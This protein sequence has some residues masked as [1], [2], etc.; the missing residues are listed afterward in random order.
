M[1]RQ[2]KNRSIGSQFIPRTKDF[3]E[4]P[5]WRT[6]TL[7]A[8]MVIERIELEFLRHAGHENGKLKV[9]YQD[10]MD[11]GIARNAV[12]PALRE[13]TEMGF[14]KCITHGCAGNANY[15]APN[16]Y[17]LTY[18]P[19]MGERDYGKGPWR[20][21]TTMEAARDIARQARNDRSQRRWRPGN[22]RP[23]N[24]LPAP[25]YGVTSPPEN[26]G[27]KAGILGDATSSSYPHKMGILSRSGLGEQ[28]TAMA[29][30]AVLAAAPAADGD[31]QPWPLP[32]NVH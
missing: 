32:Q 29:A 24:K 19:G 13:A 30:P 11:Y 5:R 17:L 31:W 23:K 27:E 7:S 20:Q 6:L 1:S 25:F 9:T 21:E 15:R 16:E 26:G 2:R 28:G 14:I 22:V 8:R 3:L 18:L 12:A 4:S 10:F